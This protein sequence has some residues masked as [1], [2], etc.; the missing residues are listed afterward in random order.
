VRSPLLT[1]SS[2][3]A[4]GLKIAKKHGLKKACVAVARKLT[5]IIHDACDVAGWQRVPLQGRAGG[6]A[7]KGC[8][9]KLIAVAA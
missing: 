3:K 6:G 1:F 2:L 5:V 4:W 8:P 9:T 7:A